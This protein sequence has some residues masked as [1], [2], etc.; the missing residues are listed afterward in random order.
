MRR[1]IYLLLFLLLGTLNANVFAGTDSLAHG[2]RVAPSSQKATWLNKMAIRAQSF[3]PDSSIRLAKQA[4]RLA[5]YYKNEKE[6]IVSYK[7]LGEGYQYLSD[8]QRSVSYYLD[9]IKIAERVKNQALLASLYNGL[10][11]D[12]YYM[13]DYKKAIDYMNKSAAMKLKLGDESS[14]AMILT[15][16]GGVLHSLGKHD[17][18]MHVLRNVEHVLIKN[19]TVVSLTSL[20]NSIG[21]IQQVGFK[22]LDS[23]L[24]YYA[25]SLEIAEKNKL[26]EHEAT[27]HHNLGGVYKDM[28][29]HQ[30]AIFHL[31]KALQLSRSIRRNSL[32]LGI[33]RTLTETYDALGDYNQA[34]RY[35]TMQLNLRD[36]I[37]QEEKQLSVEQM[38]TRYRAAKKDEQIQRQQARMQHDKAKAESDKN[39]FNTVLFIALL[40][41]LVAVAVAVYFWLRKNAEEK[42]EKEKSKIYQNIVHEIRTPLTLINGPLQN[43]KKKLSDTDSQEDIK[44]IERNSGRLINLVTELLDVAKLENKQ[45]KVSYQFGNPTVLVN[46]IISAFKQEANAK[47]IK[48]EF[49]SGNENQSVEFP[50]NVLEKIT[51]NLISNAVKYCHK[52]NVVTVI[53]AYTKEKIQLGVE[54]NGPGIAF[55]EQSKVFNRFYRSKQHI[56]MSGTGIGLSM[57]KELTELVNGSIVLNSKPGEG[58]RMEVAIP[59]QKAQ[60]KKEETEINDE[61]PSI[62]VVEDDIDVA[63]FTERTLN[64]TFNVHRATN[65]KEGLQYCIEC[66]PDIILTDIMMPVMDGIEMIT[67]IKKNELTA[68]IPVVI[69]SAKGSA[70]SRIEGLQ[71]GADG[72]LPKPFNPDELKLLINNMLLTLQKNKKEFE[73][74]LKKEIPYKER[75]KG[76]NVYLG[77]I[78]DQIIAHIENTEYSVNE[79]ADDMCVSRSQLHRNIKSITGHSTTY[80]IKLVRIEKAKDMLKAHDG[81]ITEI[82]YACGF[83]SQ[84]YFT[85]TFSEIV[86]VPPSVFQK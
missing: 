79:L 85:R 62:L 58:T 33:Y 60:P 49:S 32:T 14:Y 30:R 77:K 7:V 67:E 51:A 46:D 16:L 54:D 9:G 21:S 84:S 43:I 3:S 52:G 41:L 1:L 5:R 69:F 59:L 76:T 75:L 15:N 27:A 39:R 65:G 74:G 18:A 63:A 72:Y 44:L 50:A 56:N 82:A 68:H 29:K 19:K 86:G 6:Q 34:L 45:F 40:L 8:F 73:H 55:S 80:L 35:Q 23:A 47:E 17:S 53:L 13:G 25:K 28:G 11:V 70:E 36:S 81:N 4:L 66:I 12:F 37:F 22:S 71:S 24:F 78:V 64:D 61:W 57:V 42:L 31:Q 48:L 38:E 26:T 10:G 2:Y 83:A 20:Y